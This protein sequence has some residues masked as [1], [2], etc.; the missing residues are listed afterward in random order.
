MRDAARSTDVV[1]AEARIA[2]LSA[3]PRPAQHT[4]SE[5]DGNCASGA[6]TVESSIHTSPDNRGLFWAPVAL[7]MLRSSGD[8][9]PKKGSSRISFLALQRLT[10]Y[11]RLFPVE[12]SLPA[13]FFSPRESERPSAPSGSFERCNRRV[14]PSVFSDTA[15][16]QGFGIDSSVPAQNGNVS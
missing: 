13:Q 9:R 1:K 16:S 10:V 7:Q 3:V 11:T 5:Q 4:E 14:S 8:R 15:P 6:C 12:P 2:R